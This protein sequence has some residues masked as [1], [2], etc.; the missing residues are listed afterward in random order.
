FTPLPL[1]E[2]QS[3][4]AL[5]AYR[6]ASGAVR[7]IASID[8]DPYANPNYGGGPRVGPYA[9]DFA[10]VP[11]PGQP[12]AHLSP[13]P[14]P[15]TG[16]LLKETA[17]GWS[18]ME[19]MA[20]EAIETK[21]EDKDAP[22]RP[23][24]AQGLLVNPDGSSGLAVGGQTRTTYETAAAMRFG[25]ASSMAGSD[26]PAPIAT[27]FGDATFAVGGSAACEQAC[28]DF[29]NEGLAPDALLTHALQS[30][31]QIAASS[32]GG[33][34]DFLYTGDRLLIDSPSLGAEAF[35]RELA[36][37]AALL[38]SGGPL[39]VHAVVSPK[40]VPPDGGI[41]AFVKALEPFIPGSGHA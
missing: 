38:S 30:A 23:D 20:L 41:A 2:A 27:T 39:P 31:N 24:P 14:L 19:H 5:A 17:S 3:V 8:L 16:Y 37:Y 29:A 34:R 7:A 1:P 40:D 18:D 15:N 13:D 21:G 32:P 10:P 11:S 33:L 35:K 6:D 25:A 4:S 12:P 22:V 28:A 9:G 26:T 36:R